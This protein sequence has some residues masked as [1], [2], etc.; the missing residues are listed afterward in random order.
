VLDR[1]PFLFENLRSLV[2]SV[3]FTE[4]F[5]ILSFFCLLRSAPFLEELIV[6]GWSHGSQVVNADDKFLNAQCVDVAL[7]IRPLRMLRWER[8]RQQAESMTLSTHLLRM[9]RWKR[10]IQK[11]ASVALPLH[12]L[13][14]MRRKRHRQ[15]AAGGRLSKCGS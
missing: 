1:L 11:M 15:Q 2:I 12:P 9:L 13:R 6:C 14:M 3:D 7:S 8:Y 5:A 10:Y 4:M